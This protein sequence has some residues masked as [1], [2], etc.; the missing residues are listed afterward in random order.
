M[1]PVNLSSA[2]SIVGEVQLA[3]GTK[4]SHHAAAAPQKICRHSKHARRRMRAPSQ[5]SRE[6]VS[7]SAALTNNWRR[8]LSKAAWAGVSSCRDAATQTLSHHT[9]RFT[10]A[11]GFTRRALGR[12]LTC[13]YQER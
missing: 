6:S 4:R 12:G 5:M 7:K 1:A 10:T 3:A 9:P 11:E 13:E 2:A 8:P